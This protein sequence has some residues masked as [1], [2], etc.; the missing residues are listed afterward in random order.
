MASAAEGRS[1]IESGISGASKRGW[2]DGHEGEQYAPG[3]RTFGSC[4]S[5]PSVHH[6]EWAPASFNILSDPGTRAG[7]ECS[8]KGAAICGVCEIKIWRRAFVVDW[9]EGVWVMSKACHES[10]LPVGTCR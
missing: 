4:E 3:V 8:L 6:G 5:P 1:G 9:N 10:G 2:S 7:G